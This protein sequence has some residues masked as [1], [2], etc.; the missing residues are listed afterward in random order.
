MFA[1]HVS[2]RHLRSQV[3]ATHSG[4]LTMSNALKQ[5]VRI[6]V[7][8]L[9]SAWN[10]S[11]HTCTVEVT[12]EEE[13]LGKHLELAKA[14]AVANG[15][16]GTMIALDAEAMPPSKLRDIADW[17]DDSRWRPNP[18]IAGLIGQNATSAAGNVMER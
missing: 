18:V 4:D 15:F 9:D 6:F 16:E 2:G 10:P 1:L 8:C 14:D 12:E 7:A 17:L 3:N 5:P 11:I 13:L